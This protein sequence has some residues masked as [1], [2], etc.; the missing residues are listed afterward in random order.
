M[1]FF[2]NP[3]LSNCV[4]ELNRKPHNFEGVCTASHGITEAVGPMR[5]SVCVAVKATLA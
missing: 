5:S 4:Q 3:K 1:K 2:D